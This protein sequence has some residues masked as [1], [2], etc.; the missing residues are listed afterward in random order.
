M[1]VE[2]YI[3]RAVIDQVHADGEAH[4]ERHVPEAKGTA[5]DE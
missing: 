3:I 2:Q 5:R 4:L 1:S